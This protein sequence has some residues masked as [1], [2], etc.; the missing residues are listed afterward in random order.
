MNQRAKAL[1]AFILLLTGVALVGAACPK[2]ANLSG[3]PAAQLVVTSVTLPD[4]NQVLIKANGTFTAK[5]A[6]PDEFIITVDVPGA[7]VGADVQRAMPGM[8]VI[9]RVEVRE[10]PQLTPPVVRISVALS[11]E[12]TS[13]LQ[14]ADGGAMLVVKPVA[15]GATAP[16]AEEE[17][18]LPYA[19]ARAEV[20]RLITGAPPP[21]VA[22]LPAEYQPVKEQTTGLP[23]ILTPMP[24]G[25]P[26]GEATVVGD[27]YYR[28]LT[29]GVQVLIMTNGAIGNYTDYD[30]R[31]PA[32]LYVE[33]PG[34]TSVAPQR[35]YNLRWGGVNDITVS[36][37]SDR[38]VV[39][40]DFAGPLLAYDVKKTGSGIVVTV[41]KAKYTP[42][43]LS[44]TKYVTQPGDSLR[45]ISERVY[46]SP[47]GWNR[48]L[49]ANREAFTARERKAIEQTQGAIPL[50]TNVVLMI[51][52][53]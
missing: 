20:E 43:G 51:P 47:D 8:G 11:Q 40:I 1:A 14:S 50:G 6:S 46:G 17:V 44:A 49:S 45:S 39:G 32:M 19:E 34:L 53:R 18:V 12:A 28:T 42:G 41:Y 5:S 29:D 38:V 2:Q 35:V 33:L 15:G 25:G 30:T 52:V 4:A 21:P 36:K 16:T 7:V 48:I 3:E 9:K 27:I 13:K 22:P 37:K 31:S 23:P 10:L 24:P 26:N